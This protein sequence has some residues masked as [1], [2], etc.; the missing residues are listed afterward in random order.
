MVDGHYVE[1][2]QASTWLRGLLDAQ[3]RSE[4]TVRTYAGRLALWLTWAGM[5]MTGSAKTGPAGM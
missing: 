2:S 1:H 5:A 4:G 3:G